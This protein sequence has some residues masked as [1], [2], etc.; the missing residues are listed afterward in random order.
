MPV[1]IRPP[2]RLPSR[3]RS[4]LRTLGLRVLAALGLITFVALVAYLERDGYRDGDDLGALTLLDAF[5]YA[6]VSVTTTGYGDITPVTEGARLTTTLLVTPARILF[7]IL[8]VGT[9]VEVLAEG[10]REA[11]RR[12]TWRKRLRDH[13]IIC[14]FGTKGRAAAA[15]ITAR[16]VPMDKIVVVDTDADVIEEATR[17][18]FAAVHGQS[19]RTAVLEE[20]GIRDASAVIVATKSDEASVLTTLTARELNKSAN[21]VAAV[22]EIEN[23]HLIHESGA[24]S[25]ILSS[26]AA[27]RLLGLAQESPRLVEV[28]ED[29]MTVGQ[30]MDIIKREVGPDDIGKH[31]AVAHDA[32]VVAVVRGDRTLRFD[33]PEAQELQP[34]DWLVCL[35]SQSAPADHERDPADRG[36]RT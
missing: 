27:G 19:T 13:T 7:L 17:A 1:D 9:T 23:R 34:G 5:Y 16:G 15:T 30:G 4:P 21:I 10:S 25:A 31:P 20:A 29:L 8:L 32:P 22:R 36:P 18:G 33:A 35:S 2:L 6:S 28:L 26:G 24:D 12:T 3:K 11:I 14:G